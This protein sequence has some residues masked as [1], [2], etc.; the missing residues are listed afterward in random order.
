MLDN[1]ETL[2]DEAIDDRRM[3]GSK[4][5]YVTP[6][7]NADAKFAAFLAGAVND[8]LDGKGSNPVRPLK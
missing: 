2:F 6:M 7:F 1:S 8:A 3:L 5:A 4:P